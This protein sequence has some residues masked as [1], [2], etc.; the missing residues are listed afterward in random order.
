MIQ[1]EPC[2]VFVR[3]RDPQHTLCSTLSALF[4]TGTVSW[5]LL[6]EQTEELQAFFLLFFFA[7]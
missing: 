3:L 5:S 4:L 1:A 2:V 7:S 6:G